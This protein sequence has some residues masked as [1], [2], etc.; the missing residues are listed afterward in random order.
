ME[1]RHSEVAYALVR[2]ASR[3]VSMLALRKF[4]RSLND[5]CMSAVS[6]EAGIRE[7]CRRRSTRESSWVTTNWALTSSCRIMSICWCGPWSRRT[8]AQ[9]AKR[10]DGSC[11]E[12]SA[13]T[14]WGAVL[15]EGIVRSLVRDH[16]EFLRIRVILKRIR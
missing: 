16:A 10:L 5:L 2:A 11:C 12:S 9:I 4:R 7:D 14:D 6:S 8:L 1:L 15:A 3:L 13:R